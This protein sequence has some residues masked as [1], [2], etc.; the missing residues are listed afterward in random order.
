M[1]TDTHYLNKDEIQQ[2]SDNAFDKIKECMTVRDYRTQKAVK[3]KDV[4]KKKKDVSKKKKDDAPNPDE[5]PTMYD[6]FPIDQIKKE[7]GRLKTR[8][9]RK[10]NERN[11]VQV[12]AHPCTCARCAIEY[13]L[14]S[15]D[16]SRCK[17]TISL[18]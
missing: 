3:K 6:E 16:R 4:S 14:L 10:Q 15:A 18:L 5:I 12:R 17:L 1:A 13:Q 2:R 9:A 7:Q 11:Y 8:L